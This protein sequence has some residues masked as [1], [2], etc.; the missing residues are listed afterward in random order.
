M[1]KRKEKQM[2]HKLDMPRRAARSPSLSSS[3]LLLLLIFVSRETVESL[4]QSER[5]ELLSKAAR[6]NAQVNNNNQPRSRSSH[7]L[8]HLHLHF[9]VRLHLQRLLLLLLLLLLHTCS[10]C[11]T[12][13]LNCPTMAS[14]FVSVYAPHPLPLSL[15]RSLFFPPLK[16]TQKPN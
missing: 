13:G 4:A 5:V 9:H 15:P 12:H 7:D 1:R 2:K 16:V 10:T 8:L 14:S 6:K 11:A 3:L